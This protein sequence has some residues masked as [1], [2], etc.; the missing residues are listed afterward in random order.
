VSPACV[1]GCGVKVFPVRRAW[2][3]P[4][5]AAQEGD[6][7]L[8]LGLESVRKQPREMAPG[9]TGLMV[10]GAAGVL[11]ACVGGCSVKALSVRRARKQLWEAVWD[12]DSS[13][14]L[15]REGRHEWLREMAPGETGPT[16]M[17]R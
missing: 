6:G 13:L 4:W 1:G 9:E 11:P 14:V 7:S 2:E 10:R 17:E 15:G 3:L 12:G 8:V 5:E 16:V